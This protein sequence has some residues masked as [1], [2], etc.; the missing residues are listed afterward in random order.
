MSIIINT[1]ISSMQGIAALNKNTAAMNKALERLSTGCRINSSK[2]DAAGCAISTSLGKEVSSLNVAQNNAQMGQSMVDTANGA[3][4]NMSTMLQR[5]RDLA[6]QSANGT[7]GA[8]ERKAMQNEVENLITEMYRTKNSTEFNGKQVLGAETTNHITEEEAIVEGYTTVHTAQ[9]LKE[10]LRTNDANCKVMLFADIDLS[11][12]EEVDG[13]NWTAVSNFRG[14]FDGNGFT[15]SNLKIN[16]PNTYFQGLFGS[17]YA[18]TIKNVTL[19]N[20]DV[21]GDQIIG[22]LVAHCNSS[23]VENCSVSGNVTGNQNVGGFVANNLNSS[24]ITNCS[25]SGAVTALTKSA[26]GF[27]CSN[28][29]SSTITN[30]SSSGT[31]TSSEGDAGGFVCGNGSSSTI[32]NCSSS[33]DVI[34]TNSTSRY[35]GGFAAGNRATISNCSSSGTVTGEGLYAGG[36]L[37]ILVAQTT[38]VDSK[39]TSKVISATNTGGAFIGY[40]GGNPTLLSGNEY[41][42]TIN[43]GMSITGTRDP[44]YPFPTEDQIKDN[45]NLHIE[46]LEPQAQANQ[47]AA[48]VQQQNSG[49]TPSST[50][51][52]LQV[53]IENDTES[54]ITV[55]TGFE[56]GLFAVNIESEYGAR[57][58]LA[59]I[60]ALM[61]KMTDKQTEL[62]AIS[63]RLDSAMQYQQIQRNT[64]IATNSIIKDA[65]F[66]AESSN[67]IKQQILQQTTSSLL[68]TANQNPNIALMLLNTHRAA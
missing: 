26:G 21:T 52:N 18:A 51:V 5:I 27:V 24:T 55:D 61:T 6:E 41:N 47:A 10:A 7:Y 59:K 35:V 54:V 2:D 25:F 32:T 53:G 33:A 15:I 28:A 34:G 38:I 36:F 63:A 11:D 50:S 8:D 29:N 57:K 46:T 4:N 56:I 3:L 40:Y 14:T 58:A 1:N 65:D 37:A 64:K 67:Y 22:G 30:C 49:S 43:E 31:V 44:S 45:P 16:K 48:P 19:E 13:S 68:S 62:G 60:D 9:E 20:V 39:T 66:A 42:S 17:T 23:T 12:L